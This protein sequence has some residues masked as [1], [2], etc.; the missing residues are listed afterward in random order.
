MSKDRSVAFLLHATKKTSLNASIG[1]IC[2]NST[3]DIHW[4]FF[5]NNL[6]LLS[7]YIGHNNLLTV[8][9]IYTNFGEPKANST[10]ELHW[11]VVFY[12]VYQIA[13]L[14]GSVR[15]ASDWWAGGRRFDLRRVRQH[16]TWRLSMKYF[17]W[18][19]SLFRWFKK[20]SNQ[21]LAKECAQYWLT[22]SEDLSYPGKNVVIR[23]D[24][25]LIVMRGPLNSNP[26]IKCQDIGH[27]DLLMVCDNLYSLAVPI[28]R[29][30]F[31]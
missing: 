3:G 30:W 17:L 5:F 6:G 4:R 1:E 12:N 15:C 13:G 7:K 20:G 31:I 21:F 27:S 16:S 9:N 25:T 14:G 22:C 2:P 28:H 24:M 8:H 26:K 29:I 11:K 19:F 18:S 10:R 23:L